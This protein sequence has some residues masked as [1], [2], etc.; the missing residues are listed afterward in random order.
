MIR[1]P[2]HHE[3]SRRSREAGLLLWLLFLLTGC[4]WRQPPTL[5]AQI[6]G[7]WRTQESRYQGRFIRL[8]NG[9]ITFGLGGLA[10]DN[11]ERI[12]KVRMTP[13]E[14]PT[15]YVLTLR[16]ADGTPDSI[17]LHFSPEN[18][19][20]LRIKSQFTLVWR[21]PPKGGPGKTLPSR[22][23]AAA[24]LDGSRVEHK[25]IYK[26]DCLLPEHCHSY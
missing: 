12:E 17:A 8:D 19:G 5:P 11:T 4:S 1:L 21:H 3:A 25:T 18:G 23:Q 9:Q 22:A 26:I 7:E 6:V 20:E 16:A 15:D 2:S 13:R 24:P 10:P 14:N